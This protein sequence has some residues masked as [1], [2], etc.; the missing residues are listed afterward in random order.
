MAIPVEERPEAGR[1]VLGFFAAAFASVI[2]FMVMMAVAAGEATAIGAV[3]G[4]GVL[5]L[6]FGIPI[7]G[8][9]ILILALPAYLLMRRHWHVRW[10]NAALAGFL[11]GMAPSALLG[12]GADLE[13]LGF[14][15]AGLVGGLAFWGVVRERRAHVP[16]DPE[17]FR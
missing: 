13:S 12:G 10:W 9:V 16:V 17:T 5:A 4:I 1:V 6:L 15:A 3:L 7:A 14:G 8:V 11:I 2:A